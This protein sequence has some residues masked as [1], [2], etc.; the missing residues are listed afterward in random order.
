MSTDKSQSGYSPKNLVK[1]TSLI[2]IGVLSSRFLGFIRDVILANLLGTGIIAEAFLVAQRIPNLLRDLV[3]EGAAN[4]AIVPVLVEYQKTKSKEQWHKF[5]NVLLAWGLIVLSLL[6]LLG[7][8]LAP[9]I[10]RI[11]APGFI[12]DGA[13][14]HL[15]VELTR[16]MFPFL[17]L[18]ALTALQMG[19]LY[20]LNS[21]G[22]PAFSS[23]LMNIAMIISI[24]IAS[25]FSWAA[26]YILAAGV[27]VGGIFQL[28]FQGQA[29][30]NIG[31][32]W[33][34]PAKLGHEGMRKIAKLLLP[35]L[36]G[37]AV[38]QMN[39]FVD[40]LCA[41]L[42][43]IVGAGG[44]AA[45]Y[46]ANRLVQFPLGIFAYSLSS[47]SL[48]SLSSSA[49]DKDYVAFKQTLMFSLRNLL[50][51]LLPSAIYLLILSPLLVRVI[52]QHGAF[53]Q[54]SSD[55]TARTL[56]FLSLGLPFFGASRILVSGFYALQD[57]Q[58]SVRI[59]TVCLLIN[60][61]L[62]VI[63]MFPLQIGGIALASSVSGLANFTLLFM[64]MSDRMGGP[65]GVLKKFFIR[66]I[67]CLF[68]MAAVMF[69]LLMFLNLN[70]AILKLIL[71]SAA[72]WISFLFCCHFTRVPEFTPI[73][74]TAKRKIIAY[75]K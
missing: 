8:A 5:V 24:W 46:F 63:L 56:A 68:L 33:K 34:W 51:V 55:I 9:F 27:L 20:T 54:H 37:S 12:G 10:V 60:A 47:A 28:L 44:I 48:P 6:T 50:F 11:M 64:T 29:L 2:S 35:R 53:D 41:S 1:T 18:I 36:W 71:I 72:G 58:T 73:W 42:A 57:T 40:T 52:F 67:P 21:F 4:A 32:V 59:A 26:A 7:M 16:L 19:V 23:C 70:N 49:T 13:K 62:N 17:I 22:P 15:T 75:L 45:I 65:K 43:F 3:G 30:A 74:K 69:L 31:L 25:F 61:I 66:M 14:Y 39:I 38:Y